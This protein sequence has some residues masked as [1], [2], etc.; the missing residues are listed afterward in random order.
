MDTTR[1]ERDERALVPVQRH[2]APWVDWRPEI[3]E[4]GGRHD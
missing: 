1:D 4:R 2:G 3:A